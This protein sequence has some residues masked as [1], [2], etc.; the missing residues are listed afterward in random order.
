MAKR[1]SSKKKVVS[2]NPLTR[3]QNEEDIDDRKIMAKGEEI[4]SN[5]LKKIGNYFHL[6]VDNYE[7]SHGRLI[8]GTFF[9]LNF[10]AIILF[11]IDTYPLTDIHRAQLHLAEIILVS[12]FILEYALRMWVAQNKL[13][14]FLSIYS[15][16]DLASILPILAAF[17]DLGF[18]RIIRILR[19]VRMIRILRFQRAFKSKNTLFGQFTE[20]GLI[21]MR[22]GLTIF[23]II[24][25]SAGLMWAIEN[26]V[27]PDKFPN[28]WDAMYFSI[29]TIATVG[30]GDITPI[31][32][33]GKIITI[34]VIVA[35]LTLI[36][37]Q[38]GKLLQVM[39][40]SNVKT[41]VKCQKCGLDEHDKD[42][43]RCKLCGSPIKQKRE[44]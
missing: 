4:E 7:T 21:V 16:I 23:T 8:E 10:F 34:L 41:K 43:V 36:P 20:K 33:L 32:P 28:I 17:T 30:Y 15:I 29:V 1:A 12:I 40:S 5:L 42:A 38:L 27:N 13:K 2:R 6:H 22:I 19:L 35:G 9:I 37:W 3:M 31:S 18:L 24:F 14:H 26:K 39:I 25:V 11:I 44:E